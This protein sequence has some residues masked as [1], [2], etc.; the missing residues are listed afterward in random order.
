MSTTPAPAEILNSLKDQAQSILGAALGTTELQAFQ[1]GSLGN[2]K[3]YWQDPSSLQ[4][5]RQTYDWINSNLKSG[6]TPLQ[7]DQLFTN[8]YIEVLPTAVYSL[9][10]QDQAALNKAQTNA[11]NQQ[12]AVLQAWQAAYGTLPQTKPPMD[13]IIAQILTWGNPTPTLEQ[14]KRAVDFRRV[15]NKVPASGEPIVPVFANW[16]N[17]IGN[18]I[19]LQDAT[20]R[21]AAYK[22]LAK[23]AAQFPTA[24]NGAL[25]LN[26]NAVVPAFFVSTPLADIINGLSNTNNAVSLSMAVTRST[27]DEFTVT[28]NAKATFKIPVFD[29]LTID[30]G[31]SAKYFQSDIAT[32]DNK[33]T[34]NMSFPGV[35]YVAFGPKAFSEAEQ[36]NWY[37][38]S[39]IRDAIANKGKGDTVSGFKFS[40][41]P[42][43]VDFG[44]GGNFS[45]VKGVAISNY[46]TI[47]IEVTSDKYQR[48][49][50]TFE[51][52]ASVGIT[53]LG[54]P[55]G[56]GGSES[57]YSNHV[58]VDAANKKVTIKFS[59][60]PELVA[61]VNRD[62]V[63]W[64]L[65]VATEYPA[66]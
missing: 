24:D 66:A 14:I 7:Q 3:Y 54:I 40:P 41:E 17:A 25:T 52:Q 61:G 58:S 26:D 11:T 20:S 15:L 32:S 31:G 30:F 53:F 2:F 62:S 16:L 23:A 39:P 55:L 13:G 10:A 59:P 29:L 36:K 19:G 37:W 56:I 65:G 35:T 5:N 18:S 60:P 42:Q 64:I 4:F 12:M 22:E 50:Q 38:I 1:I 48:I 27:S 21:N 33:T 49:Q 57:T 28:V 6:V 46:P 47:T 63:G 44:E 8:I 43:G 9:S 45:Y 34:V 51:Q